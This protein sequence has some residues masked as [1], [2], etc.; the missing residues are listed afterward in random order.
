METESQENME[1]MEDDTQEQNEI[2]RNKFENTKILLS[3]T[4][5][6]LD[7]GHFKNEEKQ[8][9]SDFKI[10]AEYFIKVTSNLTLVYMMFVLF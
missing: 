4:I 2:I 7:E 3:D 10:L 9:T 6:E 8:S 1:K 5:M